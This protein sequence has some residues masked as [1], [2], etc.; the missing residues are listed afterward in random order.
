VIQ[1]RRKLDDISKERVL[2]ASRVIGCTTTGAA[3]HKEVLIAA[4]AKIVI[5]EEAG[6]ILE[7]HLL[8]SMNSS[9]VEQLVLI[10]DHKQLR[11]KCEV[12]DL[13]VQAGKGHRLNMSLF[14]RLVIEGYP[15]AVLEVGQLPACALRLQWNR[16]PW[17]R[18]YA[19]VY[20]LLF[21][22][23]SSQY[24]TSEF[25]QKTN[26]ANSTLVSN[27]FGLNAPK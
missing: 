13:S 23:S 10:G 14:E 7:A 8:T 3:I 5:V 27:L 6:E 4:M 12:Y 18:N 22:Q 25:S 19:E 1:Q 20:D 26:V 2:A 9:T 15:H 17:A 11:P 24:S 21:L 16:T